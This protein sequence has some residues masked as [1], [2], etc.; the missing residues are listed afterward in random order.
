[1]SR[2]AR[3][4]CSSPI[5]GACMDW[6]AS[7]LA[8][9]WEKRGKVAHALEPCGSFCPHGRGSPA[10]G[11]KDGVVEHGDAG[12]GP[13]GWSRGPAPQRYYTYGAG[14]VIAL[15]AVTKKRAAMMVPPYFGRP[16]PWMDSKNKKLS[17]RAWP[18]RGPPLR[19][20]AAQK[21]P[22][23]PGWHESTCEILAMIGP[24]LKADACVHPFDSK[25]LIRRCGTSQPSSYQLV[26]DWI[27]AVGGGLCICS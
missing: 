13:A 2:F 24:G 4:A 9:N 12:E 21:L 6:T 27:V 1:M 15:G 14:G 18:K 26:G 22:R 16:P 10:G 8:Q 5:C 11:R 19:R 25:T 7:L 20:W 17:R 23:V 3:A